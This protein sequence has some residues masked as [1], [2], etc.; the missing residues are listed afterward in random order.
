[1]QRAKA[2]GINVI[3]YNYWS[4]TDN[5]EWGSYTPRF[6]LYTVDVRTDPAGFD[7]G[8]AAAILLGVLIDFL[9]PLRELMGCDAGSKPPV[10]QPGHTF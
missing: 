7:I 3:G 4:I 1:M 8:I 2:D 10:P 9:A 5:Y 6:G